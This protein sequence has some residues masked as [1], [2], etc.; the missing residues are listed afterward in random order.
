MSL[1][2][3]INDSIWFGRYEAFDATYKQYDNLTMLYDEDNEKMVVNIILDN[4][5]ANFIIYKDDLMPYLVSEEKL[6]SLIN[7]IW[8]Y[9]NEE[10]YS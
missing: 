9:N 8:H 3:S 4:C 7:E 6:D 10:M 2:G 1:L 5:E